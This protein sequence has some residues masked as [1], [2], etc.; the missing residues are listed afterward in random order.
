[1]PRKGSIHILPLLFFL[2]FGIVG[3][4]GWTLIKNNP[5]VANLVPQ[6]AKKEE[7]VVTLKSDYVNPLDENAQY[8]NPFYEY[9]NPFDLL[10]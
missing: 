6:V 3:L 8:V 5:Q 1:M 7:P 9:K 10:E 4:V 2:V